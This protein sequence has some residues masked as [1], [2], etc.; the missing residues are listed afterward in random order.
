MD[1]AAAG[2]T[3]AKKTN[4]GPGE[5]ALQLHRAHHHGD[6]ERPREE[7]HPERYLPVYHGPLPLLPREQAGLAEQHPPQPVAQRVLRESAARRQEAGQ[8]QLLDARPRLLQHVREWQLSTATPAIQEEG[9]A[10]GQGGAGSPQGAAPGCGQGRP[11]G[12]PGSGRAQG[13]RE[14]S[15]GQERGGVTRTAGHH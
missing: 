4:A 11:D 9:R 6:P 3:K 10:Q 2:P 5:A 15:G 8:G 13:G 12:N 14:E 7:D 1:P